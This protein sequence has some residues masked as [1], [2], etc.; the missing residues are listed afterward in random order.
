MTSRR[1]V[2][3]L[4]GELSPAEAYAAFLIAAEQGDWATAGEVVRAMPSD[5]VA[6]ERS[7]LLSWHEGFAAVVEEFDREL[8]VAHAQ[9][10]A[11]RI[12]HQ[13]SEL[14]A[15]ALAG[16]A[17]QMYLAGVA[18]ASGDPDSRKHQK[19]ASEIWR[20]ALDKLQPDID[21]LSEAESAAR[22]RAA[23]LVHGFDGVCQAAGIDPDVVVRGLPAIEVQ[24]LDEVR[25]TSPSP[26]SRTWLLCFAGLLLDHVS[27]DALDELAA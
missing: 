17:R 8:R 24:V 11:A 10:E 15:V 9:C 19:K 20:A 5:R 3:R 16:T 23:D 13:A 25:G 7:E 18:A 6:V 12:V 22:Q 26:D 14:G 21:Q 4:Y 2:D 27:D 1:A